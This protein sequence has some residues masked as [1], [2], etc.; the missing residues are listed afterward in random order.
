M[1]GGMTN[2]VVGPA[3]TAE[4]E[5]LFTPE[6]LRLI[7]AMQRALPDLPHDDGAPHIDPATSAIR[8]GTWTVPAPPR[9]LVDVRNGVMVN[10]ADRRAFMLGLNSG[11][12]LCIADLCDGTP[13]SGATLAQAQLHLAERWTSAMDYTD[14]ETGKRMSL[15]QR[16]AAL[17]VKVRPLGVEEP[18]ISAE[19]RAVSAGIA[20]AALYLAQNAGVSLGKAATPLLCLPGIA[21]RGEAKAWSEA[22]IA[23]ESAL[24][25]ALGSVRVAVVADTLKGCYA[26]DEI[27]HALRD[28]TAAVVFDPA[29]MEADLA[30]LASAQQAKAI[31]ALPKS[32]AAY[33]VRIAHRRGALA[34]MA[35]M[36]E[37][38][39]RIAE[40]AVRVGFDGVW[41]AS[42]GIAALAAKGFNADMP[43]DNQLY[44]TRDDVELPDPGSLLSEAREPMTVETFTAHFRNAFFGI[45]AWLSGTGTASGAADAAAADHGRIAMWQVI[46]AGVMM[47]DERLANEALYDQT[48]NAIISTLKDERGEDAWKASHFREASV[49]LRNLVL[50]EEFVPDFRPLVQKKLA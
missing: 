9:E 49:M 22:L 32:L 37:A 48:A 33:A 38:E 45:E 11:A 30:R 8:K 36:S 3:L 10:A 35:G 41:C 21:S 24:G 6:A 16:I 31:P 20:D 26:L 1:S 50:G 39:R 12:R 44:F 28:H 40:R 14:P 4:Q 23:A 29:R 46:R 34:L 2:A 42:P 27:V 19:G 47:A 7:A 43:T 25:F 13:W 17:M 5:K 15:A 18:R